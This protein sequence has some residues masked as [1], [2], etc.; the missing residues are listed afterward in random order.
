MFVS[1]SGHVNYQAQRQLADGSRHDEKKGGVHIRC[2]LL[3]TASGHK[4]CLGFDTRL[5]LSSIDGQPVMLLGQ[6]KGLE[7]GGKG[8]ITDQVRNK[9]QL[10]HDFHAIFS[11]WKRCTH[12]L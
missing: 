12:A 2:D 11:K 4:K 9:Y 5:V 10:L 6:M 3:S 7:T 1:P 8:D